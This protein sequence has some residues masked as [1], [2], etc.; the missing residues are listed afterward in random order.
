MAGII[1]KESGICPVLT[2]Y[3]L[4]LHCMGEIVQL[5]VLLL[6]RDFIFFFGIR[7]HQS[8]AKSSCK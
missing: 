5:N 3:L 8:L 4:N 1:T 7:D 2:F 6:G